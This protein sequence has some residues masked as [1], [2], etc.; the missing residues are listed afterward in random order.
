[1]E[2]I[3]AFVAGFALC[4]IAF[5][6]AARSDRGALKD[7]VAFCRVQGQEWEKITRERF[8]QTPEDEIQ[9]RAQENQR[10]AAASPIIN[11]RTVVPQT[12]EQPVY[13]TGHDPIG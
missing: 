2:L 1:M 10:V 13:L 6:V 12:T 7:A 11:V 3:A 9:R 8:V 4:L 5:L